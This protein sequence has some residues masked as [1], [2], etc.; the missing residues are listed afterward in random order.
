[1]TTTTETPAR[2]PVTRPVRAPALPSRMGLANIEKRTLDVPLRILIYGVEGVGKSTFAAGAP[3][4]VFLVADNGAV[5]IKQP[6]FPPVKVWSETLEAVRFLITE[7]HDYRTLVIDPAN[8]FESLAWAQVCR[9]SGLRNI[10]DAE[11]GKGFNAAVDLWRELLALLEQLWA[12][13]GMNIIFTAHAQVKSFKNPESDDFDRYQLAMHDRAAGLLK[14]W[15][16]AVLFAKHET[17]TYRE[18][19][20]KRTRAE[21]NGVR[22]LYTQWTAAYDAK[23]RYNLPERLPLSWDDFFACVKANADGPSDER[24]ARAEALL[25]DI[26]A[27]IAAL[28]DAEYERKA[29]PVIAGAADD[30]GKLAEIKN[31]IAAR[32]AAKQQSEA[33]E[34]E[35][36]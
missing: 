25:G 32:V 30:L 16:D 20:S 9:T 28:A 5:W 11:Y 24:K 4:P 34:T 3:N 33:T 21:S 36:A 22:A 35:A 6:K 17:H 29:R 8:W 31:R 19:G 1:M 23:N 27:L 15:C 13:R 2:A 7:P 18:K 10:A 26:D 12:T 14:Q